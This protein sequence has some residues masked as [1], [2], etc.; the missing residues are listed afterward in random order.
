MTK[1]IKTKM[2]VK[3]KTTLRRT[4]YILQ[5]SKITK[6]NPCTCSGP[7]AFTENQD[8]RFQKQPHAESFP[9]KAQ[10]RALLLPVPSYMQ[11][12]R[13]QGVTHGD[14]AQKVTQTGCFFQ[15]YV[16]VAAVCFLA[17]FTKT[18][19]P[20]MCNLI[21]GWT[22]TP[23]KP[24]RQARQSL[25]T[26]CNYCFFPSSTWELFVSQS[27]QVHVSLANEHTCTL[28]ASGNKMSWSVSMT[29]DS[30][31]TISPIWDPLH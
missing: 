25:I 8:L 16:S 6:R 28:E 19:Y 29:Q 4:V 12:S 30:L 23:W 10:G 11:I 31:R 17:L 20:Q 7:G 27:F 24:S 22:W 15:A 13:A 2:T 26:S 1:F 21:F 14:T 3:P 18:T 9:S 5:K